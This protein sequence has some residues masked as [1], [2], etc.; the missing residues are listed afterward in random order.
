M[1]GIVVAVEAAD[2][3]AVVAVAGVS[4]P[5]PYGLWFEFWSWIYSRRRHPMWGQE[6]FFVQ[7]MFHVT[8]VSYKDTIVTILFPNSYIS[9]FYD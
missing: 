9:H 5:P 7:E 3:V 4:P 1:I 6:L 2:A 8:K